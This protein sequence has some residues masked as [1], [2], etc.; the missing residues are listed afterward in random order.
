[1]RIGN[2]NIYSSEIARLR[3]WADEKTTENVTK[4]VT[5]K[6]TE[7]ATGKVTTAYLAH[8][9]VGAKA[10][11]N[12]P[13]AAAACGPEN[14]NKL[15]NNPNFFS[16]S[17]HMLSGAATNAG[18][19]RIDESEP[20]S[21][22]IESREGEGEREREQER[23]PGQAAGKLSAAARQALRC[24]DLSNHLAIYLSVYSEVHA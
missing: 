5:E 14:P 22:V 12:N 16:S 4:K 19:S 3:A 21:H 1:M 13:D 2:L 7:N 11:T 17:K 18:P 20:A 15:S 24:V 6:V 23:E 8:A 10:T 9:K